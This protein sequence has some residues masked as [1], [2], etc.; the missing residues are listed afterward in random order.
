MYGVS[1]VEAQLEMKQF[2]NLT[3]S[4]CEQWQVPPACLID[5]Y[6]L[7]DAILVS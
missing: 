5:G 7:I 2:A 6:R 1:F 4:R 3:P